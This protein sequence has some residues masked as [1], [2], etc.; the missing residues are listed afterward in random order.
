LLVCLATAELAPGREPATGAP[1]S[2]VPSFHTTRGE[3]NGARASS[4]VYFR[5]PTLVVLLAA[6]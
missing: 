1:D 6:G 3:P 2:T 5:E 4:C